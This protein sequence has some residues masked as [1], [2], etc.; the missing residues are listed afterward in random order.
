[1]TAFNGVKA[2]REQLKL[3]KANLE[4]RVAMLEEANASLDSE[5]LRLINGMEDLRETNVSFESDVRRLRQSEA[6]LSENL[7][8]SEAALA[9]RE[10][11]LAAREQE[12]TKLRGAY[13][14]LVEDLESEVAAGQIQIEQLRDGFSLNLSQEV[15]FESGSANLAPGG[16]PVLRAVAERVQALPNRVEVH[17]HTDDVALAGSALYPSNWELAAAR[18]ARVV[19]LLVDFGVSPDRLSVVSFGEHAPIAPNDTPEGR[20]ANRRIEIRLK[21]AAESA[22]AAEVA[23]PAAEEPPAADESPAPAET[24]A[25]P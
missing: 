3:E 6:Q 9:A 1:M 4:E 17:G 15:M 22:P 12:L 25:A 7:S 14:G 13:V 24:P 18:S 10:Q 8:V 5:R 21:P 19:R 16:A 11:A 23:P 20:A 2:E